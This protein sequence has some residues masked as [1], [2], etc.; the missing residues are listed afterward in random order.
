MNNYLINDQKD[1]FQ[2]TKKHRIESIDNSNNTFRT[3]FNPIYSDIIHLN[4]DNGVYQIRQEATYP[5]WSDNLLID[6][7]DFSG[8]A[9]KLKIKSKD[10]G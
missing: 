3:S 8:E 9:I 4:V 2:I 7:D 5:K 10:F 1:T 6:L